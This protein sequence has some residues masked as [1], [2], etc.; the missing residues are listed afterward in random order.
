MKKSVEIKENNGFKLWNY[1]KPYKFLIF[2]SV[3]LLILDI[4][5]TT[6]STILSAGFLAL[7][8]EREFESALKK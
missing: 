3:I 2:C 1:F 4:V 8:T 5:F 6:I 7:V